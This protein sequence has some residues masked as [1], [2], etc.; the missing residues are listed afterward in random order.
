VRVGGGFK[1][2]ACGYEGLVD[3]EG[4]LLGRLLP[5]VE[6]LAESVGEALE[7]LAAHRMEQPLGLRRHRMALHLVMRVMRVRVM[8]WMRGMG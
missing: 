4:D 1:P 2:V 5:L 6:A 3:L 7:D 8:R